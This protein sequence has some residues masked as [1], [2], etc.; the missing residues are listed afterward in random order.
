MVEE[1]KIFTQSLVDEI[2]HVPSTDNNAI[3]DPPDG[4]YGWI[5]VISVFFVHVFVL[6]NVYSFGV[7]YPIYIDVFQ[8]T[9]AN[10]A[11]I[12]SIGFCML[13]GFG[14]LAGKWADE[15]GNGLVVFIGGL[16]ISSGYFIS[17]Y[18]TALWQ[19]YLTHGFLVGCG[20]S[21]SF[22]AGIGV[23]GQWFSARR[24]L[25]TGLAVSGSGLG[26]F[27]M[28][29]TTQN[30]I[31]CCGWRITLRYLALISVIGLTICG[32][33][34]RRR[35]PCT[36]RTSSESSFTMFKDRNFNL[37][38]AGALFSS[39]GLVMPFTHLPLYAI[40]N[41]ISRSNAVWL[42]SCM[43]IASAVGRITMGFFADIYGKMRMLILCVLGGGVSTLCWMA[44]VSFPTLI[45]YS[46]VFGLFAGG[47]I[48]LM[49]AVTAEL[50]GIQRLS[51]ILGLLYTSTSVGNLLSAPIG[52]YLFAVYGNYNLSISVAGAFM[53]SSLLFLVLITSPSASS[54]TFTSTAMEVD[55]M[56]PVN[57]QDSVCSSIE[58]QQLG[59]HDDAEIEIELEEVYTVENADDL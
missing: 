28:S 56:I 35:I 59:S 40:K 23:I 53:M 36:K 41:G 19:L 24:G 18:S 39:L 27:A 38:Y 50:F 21:L 17:S 51:S 37:L 55:G 16:F 11:W 43:G 46:A 5:V 10:I 31:E 14:G 8:D 22:V 26:Q 2:D 52:G 7:F 42:L 57:K 33:F 6:G 1:S 15:F 58:L 9:P 44:C 13:A 45:V 4:E 20:Y 48:S 47:L 25:A 3:N 12:G 49:P 34:I 54:S 32:W 30:L 29:I